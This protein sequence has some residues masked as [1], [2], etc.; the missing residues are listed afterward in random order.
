MWMTTLLFN[1]W[2]TDLRSDLKA[3]GCR[4][5]LIMDNC[6]SQKV[7]KP[8]NVDVTI[9]IMHDMNGIEVH[10]LTC[11]MLPPNA[12]SLI[13]PLDQGIIAMVKARYRAWFLRWM[14]DPV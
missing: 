7:F 10:N 6:S 11:I 12:T 13:Q 8:D 14:I 1:K 3:K 2:L 9:S 4:V 5:F